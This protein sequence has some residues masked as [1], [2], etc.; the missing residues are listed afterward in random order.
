M[1]VVA[2]T[3][4]IAARRLATAARLERCLAVSAVSAGRVLP[5]T[6]LARAV[7]DRPGPVVLEAAE[8]QALGCPMHQRPT[9]PAQPPSWRAAVRGRG[10]LGGHVGRKGDGDPG[11][12]VLGKGWQQLA[13]RT[14]MYRSMKP[15]PT[16]EEVGKS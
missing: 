9:P 13:D 6:R 16:K 12:T 11:V 3:G 7:P 8:G 15:A 10:R 14:T 1:L 4:R 2:S 5:A